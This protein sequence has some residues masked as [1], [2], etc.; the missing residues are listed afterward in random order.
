M[1][2]N[3][4]RYGIYKL[5]AKSERKNQTNSIARGK[6][7]RREEDCAVRH[8]KHSRASSLFAIRWLDDGVRM[9]NKIYCVIYK[10]LIVCMYV[11]V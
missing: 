2:E 6:K 4:E 8:C 11:S 7:G 1:K 10:L 5:Y 9:Y 3:N